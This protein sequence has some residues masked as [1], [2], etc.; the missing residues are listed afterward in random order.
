VK[1]RIQTAANI[2]AMF[3]RIAASNYLYI[4]AI[5]KPGILYKSISLSIFFHPKGS[6]WETETASFVSKASDQ[7]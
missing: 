6:E 4:G 5:W 7:N 2:T 1:K 3:F